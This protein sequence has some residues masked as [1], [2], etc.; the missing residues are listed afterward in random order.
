VTAV[1]RRQLSDQN[2]Q[3][4][5]E[6]LV[7]VAASDQVITP[8]EHKA[9][10]KLYDRLGLDESHLD[11]VLAPLI[12]AQPTATNAA[13]PAPATKGFHLDL[14]AISRI[15]TETRAVAA[16]L[17]EAMAEEEDSDDE[18]DRLPAAALPVSSPMNQNEA[19][20]PSTVAVLAESAVSQPSTMSSPDARFNSLEPRYRP[21]LTALLKQENWSMDDAK[22]LA[23][24]HRVMLS[25]AIEA[26]NE[27][28]CECCGDWLIEDGD[29]LVVRRSLL[30]ESA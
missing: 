28:S 22:A 16:I 30:P 8:A 10:R 5:G 13:A 1:L 21:F 6:Y 4:V 29:P 9:L 12:P 14:S 20:L 24:D 26:V 11:R 18:C 3:L 15:M 7:G 23:R 27:W 17:Q 25:G 19:V 2:R